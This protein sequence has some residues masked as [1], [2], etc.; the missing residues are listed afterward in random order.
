[1]TS[2]LYTTGTGASTISD[3]SV[4]LV[5]EAMGD[6]TRAIT[7]TSGLTGYE[8][9]RPAKVIVP[10]ITPLI[11]MLPPATRRGRGCRPLEGDHELRYLAQLGHAG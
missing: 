3:E 6:A 10:V 9:E 5:R 2:E 8:L 1:M 4:T 11:N 7:M